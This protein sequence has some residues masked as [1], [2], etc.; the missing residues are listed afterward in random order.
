[1]PERSGAVRPT[2]RDW[3]DPSTW[4]LRTRLVLVAMALLVAICG[5]IGIVSYASMDFF[6]T[7]QLDNQLAQASARAR[8]FWPLQAAAR[9]PLK[10]ASAP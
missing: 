5:A 8:D 1:M 9:T 6:L 10:H 2:G 4:H 7:R 3:R